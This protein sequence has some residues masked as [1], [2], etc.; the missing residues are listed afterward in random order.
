M[1]LFK[2]P[3]IVVDAFTTD[4]YINQYYPI[5][6]ASS[7]I[8][9]WLT[10]TPAH[11]EETNH[12][13]L[14]KKIPTIKRCV[15]IQDNYKQGFILPL[16]SDLIINVK[17]SGEYSWAW[18]NAESK[19]VVHPRQQL[20]K[21]FDN[22]LHLKLESPWFLK[23]KTGVN[24]YWSQPTWNMLGAV[25]SIHIPPAIINY[26]YQTGTNINLLF[27]KLDTSIELSVGQPLAHI[28]PLTESTVEIKTH[29]ISDAEMTKFS[30]LHNTNSTFLGKYIH[31]K[32]LMQS[33]EK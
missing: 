11:Y 4:P 5:S 26:K 22:L 31:N 21:G 29:V 25:T 33:L 9:K 19:A 8:P 20:G 30:K 27:P 23:E 15:G 6:K 13:G 24:F 2:K 12:Y 18:A 10:E 3:K 16:W 14:T 7:F 28:I 17:S 32:K 1:F